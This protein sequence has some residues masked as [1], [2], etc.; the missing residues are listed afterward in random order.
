LVLFR[1][2][3]VFEI[4]SHDSLGNPKVLVVK[5]GRLTKSMGLYGNS[6]K[7]IKGSYS[8]NLY[9][10]FGLDE[11]EGIPTISGLTPF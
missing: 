5:G 9:N 3:Y 10:I 6:D 1:V 11:K 4:I 7:V 2:C 8:T